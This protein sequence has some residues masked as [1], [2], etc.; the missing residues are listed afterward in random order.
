VL[1]YRILAELLCRYTE[2]V[3]S[4]QEEFCEFSVRHSGIE[5]LSQI[6]KGG[7]ERAFGYMFLPENIAEL[8]HFA[9]A[10]LLATGSVAV[11]VRAVLSLE[12]VM[13][14]VGCLGASYMKHVRLEEKYRRRTAQSTEDSLGGGSAEVCVV[15]CVWRNVVCCTCTSFLAAAISQLHY[16]LFLY[17]SS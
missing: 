5:L 8:Q 15:Q 1:I 6:C 11:D 10:N 7:K 13:W 2:F 14:C 12:S 17:P 16:E 3:A 4:E 9:E